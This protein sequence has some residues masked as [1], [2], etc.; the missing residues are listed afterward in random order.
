MTTAEQPEK[1]P[2]TPVL[3]LVLA[4]HYMADADQIYREEEYETVVTLWYGLMR[5]RLASVSLETLKYQAG[6]YRASTALDAYLAE[7]GALFTPEQKLCVLVNIADIAL[8][9]GGLVVEER[10]TFQKFLEE[11]G[12]SREEIEPYLVGITM[13]HQLSSFVA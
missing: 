13:R 5:H 11:F 3:A 4:L 7:A 6:L 10:E 8:V 12:V 2:L 9:D 1:P